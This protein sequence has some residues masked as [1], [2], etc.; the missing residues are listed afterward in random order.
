MR[1]NIVVFLTTILLVIIAAMTIQPSLEAHAKTYTISTTSKPANTT[2]TKYKSYNNDTKHY[3]LVRSYLEKIE[4]DGGGTLVLK[5]GKYTISNTLY[6]PTAATLKMSTGVNIVK[7]TTTGNASFNP[8]K[9]IFQI[10]DIYTATLQKGTAAEYDGAH[11]VKIIGSGTATIDLNNSAKSHG[12]IMAHA[13]SVQIQG[14]HFKNNNTGS[15]IQIAGSKNVTVTDNTFEDASSKTKI[16]AILL[17]TAAANATTYKVSWNEYDNTPNTT[18]KIIN[19]K[20]KNQYAA[21]QT[22]SYMDGK[23]QKSVIIQQNKFSN[24]WTE[25]LRMVNWYK[26]LIEN[27]HFEMSG[28]KSAATIIAIGVTNPTIKKNRFISSAKPLSFEA[29]SDANDALV[30]VLSLAN[31]RDLASNMGQ[32]LTNYEI[33]LPAG[34]YNNTGDTVEF[35]NMS[36]LNKDV[37][38]FND[39]M[40]PLNKSYP[41]RPSYNNQTRTYYVLRSIMEQLEEQGGGKIVIEKG[42]YT[43]TNSLFVP[44]NVTI[45]LQDGVTL[46]KGIDS[47]A[48]TMPA[49]NSIFQFVAPSKGSVKGSVGGFNGSQNIKLYSEGRATIDLQEKFFSFAVIMAHTKNISFENIDFKNMNSGHFIELDASKDVL[50]DHCRFIGS[51]SVDNMTKEAI[52]L[53]TPDL[54]TKGF[55]SSWSNFDRTATEDIVIQNS[56][57][58]TLD[59]AIGTHKYSGDGV[60]QGVAYKSM[61]HTRVT[62]R[63]NIFE[64]IRNDAIRAM[65]WDHPIIEG[66][67]FKHIGGQ[68][69]GKRAI[70]SSGSYSPLFQNNDFSHVGRAMQFFPWKN[71]VNAVEYAIIYDKLPAASLRALETNKGKDL[72][73][74]FIRISAKYKVYTNPKKVQF[75]QYW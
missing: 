40:E 71:S 66:N 37:Y 21:L 29:F 54:A 32:G 19:N 13:N 2:Y 6:V 73:E 23:L 58:I 48:V 7:G 35:S 1:T 38:Y 51:V 10:I 59:R 68:D 12:I 33:I 30:N 16:P 64:D 43:I 3:Y 70:L 45:E 14:I 27:N 4:E 55:S 41:Y 62:I 60:I 36:D 20:F 47:G 22:A 18:I 46:Y 11:K 26:P 42:D 44:S 52:N 34:D 67:T 74:Y 69:K 17:E 53:D 56:Q 5:K 72:D 31:K 9:T 15:F 65:N 8:S 57:F 75:K 28:Q 61:P 25:A 39:D 63:N 49:S 24:I 50:I